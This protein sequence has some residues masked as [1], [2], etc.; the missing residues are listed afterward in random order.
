M[1]HD[2]VLPDQFGVPEEIVY[3]VYVGL[4]LVFLLT[5][6]RHI[7]RTDFVLLAIAFVFFGVSII[8]DTRGLPGLDPFLL[9][10]G[11][12]AIGIL[13]WLTYFYREGAI[14]LGSGASG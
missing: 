9:E 2:A 4:L 6:R 5:F 13:S 8:A 11:A 1:L 12:K 10:D 7:H 14:A 3:S